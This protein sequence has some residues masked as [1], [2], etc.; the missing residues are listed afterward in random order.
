MWSKYFVVFILLQISVVVFVR[1]N[2]HQFQVST[3]LSISKKVL[4]RL[5][6]ESMDEYPPEVSF[7]FLSNRWVFCNSSYLLI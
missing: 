3:N 6:F 1:P 7:L 2:H 4:V 5:K